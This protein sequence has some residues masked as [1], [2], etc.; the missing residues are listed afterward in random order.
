MYEVL[1]LSILLI[2]DLFLI[3]ILK[4]IQNH[5]EFQDWEWDY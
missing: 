1:P 2:F 5:S 3:K 4:N